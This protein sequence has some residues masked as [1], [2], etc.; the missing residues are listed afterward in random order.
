MNFKN[1]RRILA[2]GLVAF[3]SGGLSSLLRAQT[4]ESLD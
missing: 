1:S 3:L 4:S 2:L